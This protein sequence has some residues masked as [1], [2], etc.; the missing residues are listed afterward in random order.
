ME[1]LTYAGYV[2]VVSC[3]IVRGSTN[4]LSSKVHSATRIEVRVSV[5]YC[6]EQSNAVFIMAIRYTQL[7]PESAFDLQ[8]S[9]TN[10]QEQ[11]P[12]IAD[13]KTKKSNLLEQS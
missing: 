2:G 6:P 9:I 10:S 7:G 3:H 1:E 5:Q 12:E 11:G 13:K 8:S 4:A